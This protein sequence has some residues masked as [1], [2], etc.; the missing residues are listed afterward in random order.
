[1]IIRILK[2]TQHW[3]ILKKTVLKV[4][5]CPL[6]HNHSPLYV[7]CSSKGGLHFIIFQLQERMCL[8]TNLIFTL[9]LSWIEIEISLTLV[10]VVFIRMLLILILPTKLKMHFFVKWYLF[11]FL[12]LTL[13]KKKRNWT[14]LSKPNA[15]CQCE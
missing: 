11:T 4:D 12:F 8:K 1:M 2:L 5:C 10:V 13:Y 15:F 9:S 14:K 3:K 6:L 7:L